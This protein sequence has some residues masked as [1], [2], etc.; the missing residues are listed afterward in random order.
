M[1]SDIGSSGSLALD[2]ITRT[3]ERCIFVWRSKSNEISL[4][5]NNETDLQTRIHHELVVVFMLCHFCFDN[6]NV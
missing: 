5:K 3:S 4:H 1:R 2:T 6:I